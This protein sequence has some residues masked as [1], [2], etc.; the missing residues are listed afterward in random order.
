MG[1]N[2]IRWP[3]GSLRVYVDPESGPIFKQLVQRA[4]NLWPDA[5]A[6]I[7]AFADEVTVGHVQQPYVD[8]APRTGLSYHYHKC[9]CGYITAVSVHGSAPPT[10]AIT[11]ENPEVHY[12][13]TDAEG[14]V[15]EKKFPCKRVEI[16]NNA[17]P[18]V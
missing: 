14:N 17:A 10:Y 7:K 4:A 16:F 18:A 15:S 8:P 11:C 13:H 3:D 5:P 9:S 6:E 12:T 1:I 2:V